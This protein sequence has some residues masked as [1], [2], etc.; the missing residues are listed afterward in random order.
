MHP[1]HI[2]MT[3][4]IGS[5]QS[6][7]EVAAGAEMSMKRLQQIVNGKRDIGPSDAGSL[8]MY[9]GNGAAFWSNLQRRYDRLKS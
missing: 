7:H 9:F 2:L 6:L 8:G 3:H 5:R 4:F 1:G